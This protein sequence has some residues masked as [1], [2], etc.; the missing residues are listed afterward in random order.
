MPYR[1][2][3][4]ELSAVHQEMPMRYH[5]LP[6]SNYM[7]S[8]HNSEH[9][10]KLVQTVQRTVAGAV[11]PAL[12]SMFMVNDDLTAEN[13]LQSHTVIGRR[14]FTA[15]AKTLHNAAVAGCS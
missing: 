9:V 1:K 6:S 11:H 13:G 2:S 3:V 5:Y 14:R 7:S 4:Q 10:V 8:K 15:V 12:A